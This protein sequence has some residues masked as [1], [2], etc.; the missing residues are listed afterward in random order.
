MIFTSDLVILHNDAFYASESEIES[1]PMIYG[2]SWNWSN[3]NGGPLTQRVIR[4]I[5]KDIF[6]QIPL[7]SFEGY[8]PVIDTKSVLLMPGQYPCIPGWHCDGVIRKSKNSQP[9]LKTLNDGIMHYTCSIGE[10]ETHQGTEFI[11]QDL[12]IFIDP[13]NV[14]KS[15]DK[16]I[17]LLIDKPKTHLMKSGA[18][19]KFSRSTLHRGTPANTRQWRYFFRLSFYHM[20]TMNRIRN[21]VQIYTDIN[22]GW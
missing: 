10:N 13:N 16:E 3:L 20:P 21:Q 9:D 18:V 7:H 22:S 5:E 12:D 11:E 8:H 2:G 17:Q 15:A 14:W 1:E 19:A 4:L 6:N